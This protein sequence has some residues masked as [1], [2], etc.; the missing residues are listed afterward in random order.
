MAINYPKLFT[1]IGKYVDKVNDYYAQIATYTSDQAAIETTLA[2]ESA[3]W[4]EGSLPEIYNDFKNGVTDNISEL[5]NKVTEIL[6]DQTLVGQHLST[7]QSPILESVFKQLMTDWTETAVSVKNNTCSVGSVTVETTNDNSLDV[8][9]S[10]TLDGVT[11]PGSNLL[12]YRAYSGK[13]SELAPT[14]ETIRITCTADSESGGLAQGSEQF[15][16][17]GTGAESSGYS[18]TS[19]NVGVLGSITPVE[20]SPNL[21]LNGSFDSWTGDVLNNWVDDGSGAT[22]NNVSTTPIYGSGLAMMTVQ[23]G[24]SL[25]LHQTISA[26]SFKRDKAYCLSVWL[27][28]DADAYSD[29]QI[30]IIA[31]VNGYPTTVINQTPSETTF[32]HFTGM[33]VIPPELTD[34]V[35]ISIT[36][37]SGTLN[38]GNDPVIID[39]LTLTEARYVAGVAVCLSCGPNK[40]LREDYAEFTVAND[41]AGKFQTFF[42]KAYGVQLPS[43]ASPTISDSLVT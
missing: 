32:R 24:T 41:N 4:L 30:N 31:W 37:G 35:T 2:A 5:I 8:A 42:R 6:L 20:S 22:P 28:K 39:N 33:V 11:D 12:S 29:Q 26:G 25:D 40:I 3:V 36:S 7:G 1:I 15:Q 16:I 18:P 27:A 21:I 10:T 14:N 13:M 23:D 19:E 38:A 9:V 17:T 43:S 34:D